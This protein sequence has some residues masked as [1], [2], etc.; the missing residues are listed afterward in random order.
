MKNR[1]KKICPR[2]GIMETENRHQPK[3]RT[4]FHGRTISNILRCW[5]LLQS[6]WRI[7]PNTSF[8]EQG[9]DYTENINFIKRDYDHSH[10]FSFIKSK[11]IQVV[12]SEIRKN[13]IKAVFSK[14]VSYNRFVEIMKMSIVPNFNPRSPWG[15]RQFG[16]LIELNPHRISIHALREE[17][18][19]C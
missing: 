18:D 17:S 15:E 9:T 13:H 12:L 14:I 16:Y 5:R 4:D 8:N 3:E 7:L 19:R 6:L 2:F 1:K 10:L 11:K